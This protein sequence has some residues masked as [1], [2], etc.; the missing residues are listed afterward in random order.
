MGMAA[1]FFVMEA[2]MYRGRVLLVVGLSCAMLLGGVSSAYAQSSPRLDPEKLKDAPTTADLQRSGPKGGVSP[3]ALAYPC[4]GQTDRPHLSTHVA[5]T[6]NVVARTVCYGTGVYVYTE[7]YRDRW[8]GQ[9]FL[10]SGSGSGTNSVSTNAS[11]YCRGAGTYTY[12]AYSYH[13]ATGAGTAN[14]ANSNRFAC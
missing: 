11:W 12:R 2:F 8:Y 13:S 14:T 9:Q 10:D 5:G 7:L 6:A 3:M 4:Y 1:N